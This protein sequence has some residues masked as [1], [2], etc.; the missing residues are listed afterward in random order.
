MKKYRLFISAIMLM[1][2]SMMM[3]QSK[4]YLTREITPESLVKIYEAL[5]V[6][7]SGRVAVKIS[8]GEGPNPNYLKPTLIRNLVDSVHGTI[9]E[10]RTAYPGDRMKTKD[11]WNVIHQHG[12]DSLF[13]VDLMDE[14]D[15][16]RIPIKD[17]THLNYD[18]VGGHLANYDFLVCL[19]HFKG[20]PMGGFGGALK[21]LS[22]GC[23]SRNG[24]AYIHSAGKVQS[25]DSLWRNLGEQDDFLES[26]A[27]T[28]QSIVD[29]F[30]AERGIIFINVMNNMSIDCDCVAHP[31]TVKLKD[32]G[33]LASTDP[34]ALDQACVD[35]IKQ[36]KI[37]TGN[38]PTDMLKRID[39]Q[40]G[41]HILDWAEKIGLGSKKY[42]IINI[43]KR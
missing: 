21:N 11:H 5:G 26:M 12:F 40:H 3:A 23:A 18:I 31:A 37:T 13:A 6:K 2:A 1:T 28:A 20:H 24:K 38:D 19:S 30:K 42:Q 41:T 9:V 14:Y 33:I 22:I 7:A 15:E 32:Y 8:T 34:V 17:H 27:A 36:E 43:D 16:I 29:Y 39:K 35:I 25:P 4:V 10:C